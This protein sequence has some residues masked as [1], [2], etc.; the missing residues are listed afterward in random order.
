M[1]HTSVYSLVWK[2][3]P[4]LI[5]PTAGVGVKI[6]MFLAKG[7]VSKEVMKKTN[8]G[9]CSFASLCCLINQVIDLL[10]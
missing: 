4:V 10:K 1:S 9:V 3:I 6:C 8:D 5:L 2:L 7:V